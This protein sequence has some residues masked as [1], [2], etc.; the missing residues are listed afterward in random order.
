[1]QVWYR[2]W[3][4][5]A[6][7]QADEVLIDCFGDESNSEYSEG[8]P[9]R[10]AGA[11]VW[12]TKLLQVTGYVQVPECEATIF[13]VS[14]YGDGEPP[15][16]A[17]DFYNNLCA[18]PDGDAAGKKIAILGLGNSDYP[19]YLGFAKNLETELTR[20]LFIHICLRIAC[21]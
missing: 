14:T 11:S 10:Y 16:S 6:I 12:C 7:F 3:H 19:K 4:C 2:K 13:V 15:A 8:L 9:C 1:M 20:L 21:A 17:Q 18:A 5:K